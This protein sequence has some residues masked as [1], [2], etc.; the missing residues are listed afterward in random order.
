M[1]P[2]IDSFR[3]AAIGNAEINFGSL[4]LATFLSIFFLAASYLFFKKKE[5][6]FADII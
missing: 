6:V 1:A 4:L 2:L 3:K 5:K